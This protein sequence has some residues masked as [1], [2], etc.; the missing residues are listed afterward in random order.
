MSYSKNSGL[1]IH[2]L[3]V[4]FQE[5]QIALSKV[6]IQLPEHSIY[7]I[8]GPSGCG[9]STLLRSVAGLIGS[10]EGEITFNGKALHGQNQGLIGLVPQNYGLLPWKTVRSNIKTA[11]K[12]SHSGALSKQQQEQRI[13]DWLAAMGIADLANRYPLSL[14]GGEQQRVAIARAFAISPQIML[15]DE[16][17]SALDALTREE[18]QRIFLNNWKSHPTTALFVTHDV[19]E[20]ILLG[21][22]IV[23]MASRE[24]EPPIIMDNPLFAI[25]TEEKRDS[26][27]FFQM[28]RQIRKVMLDKW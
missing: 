1:E 3:S 6:N 8:L 22:K 4:E 9:K 7:T 13:M 23:L 26:E 20:A 17:F 10:Y 12:I 27:Q 25:Q 16:P 14:S 21:E 28:C 5:G 15:L 11:M 18:I 19:E 24:D 2:N